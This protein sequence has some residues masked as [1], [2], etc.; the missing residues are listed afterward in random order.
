MSQSAII[1]PAGTLLG[2][3]QAAASLTPMSDAVPIPTRDVDGIPGERA[4][5][6]LR[7]HAAGDRGAFAELVAD[8]QGAAFATAVRIVVDADL[9][10]DVVQEA[11]LRVLRHGDRYDAKRPFRPWLMQIVRN[12]AIDSLRRRRHHHDVAH[13]GE[14]AAPDAASDQGELRAC[15]A[16]VLGDLPEKYR[17]LIVMR[18][19]E[20][21][22]V[23]TIAEQI[24][25]DYGTTR[26]RLH[27][28]RRLFRAAWIRRYGEDR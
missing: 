4:A 26:W 22:A 10:G 27:E 23:E 16:T 25:V 20:G 24:A 13:I 15:V 19:L 9:A 6:Q 12:L 1:W 21:V 11:F 7:R 17:L 14:R 5:A 28:A 18:E 2:N 3:R 8:H